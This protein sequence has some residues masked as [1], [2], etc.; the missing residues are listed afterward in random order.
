MSPF[1][2]EMIFE[3]SRS[4]IIKK[5][6]NDDDISTPAIAKS[7]SYQLIKNMMMISATI[8]TTVRVIIDIFW[9]KPF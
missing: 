4:F 1:V 2:A 5:K 8:V 7:V 6:L 3:M 9:V